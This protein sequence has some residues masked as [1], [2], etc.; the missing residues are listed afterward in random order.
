[1]INCESRNLLNVNFLAYD[2]ID[3]VNRMC[4]YLGSMYQGRRSAS[5]ESSESGLSN[6]QSMCVFLLA[7]LPP[8]VGR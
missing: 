6:Y 8:L 5:D 7:S 2:E 4:V 1:M 3:V